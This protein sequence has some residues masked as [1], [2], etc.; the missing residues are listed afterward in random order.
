M[1]N[2]SNQKS[3]T[4]RDEELFETELSIPAP[5]KVSNEDRYV[6]AFHNNES[7]KLKIN[8]VSIYGMELIRTNQ[9]NLEATGLLRS[10][11][12][13]GI[14]FKST[15][16]F[17]LDEEQNVIAK[18]EFNLDGLGTIPA[19]GAR[20]WKFSFSPSDIVK[21]VELPMSEWSLAFELKQEHQLDLEESWEESIAKKTRLS[22]EEI[23]ANAPTLKPGE[24]NF[25]GISA[26]AEEDKGLSV[27]LL[28]RNGS[29]K[30]MDLSQIPLGVKDA[31][32]IEV[33]RG[34][35]TL[36]NFTV[37]ANTSKPWTFIF[38]TTMVHTDDIDL[39][40]WS[41]YLIQ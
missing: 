8:Q 10:T 39:T 25:M 6:Y 32:G 12:Q 11:V 13:Q 24:V 23:V 17:L 35:F 20:P 18:K 16:I 21:S 28:I 40:T 19:N 2:P 9:G 37:K 36:D 34:A 41:V 5:W 31:T 7:P 3:T 33:A 30:N 27:T 4:Q 29:G 26:K 1:S 38:P 22:L 14:N 15:V